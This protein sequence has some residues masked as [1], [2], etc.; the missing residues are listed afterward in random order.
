M[1]GITAF[2]R[3][4]TRFETLRQ[5]GRGYQKA[6]Q[7]VGPAQGAPFNGGIAE[8]SHFKIAGYEF[9]LD[10]FLYVLEGS[11]RIED[12]ENDVWLTPGQGVFIPKG[13]VVTIEV[14]DRMVWVYVSSPAFA[15]V[16]ETKD[17]L[18]E[19]S[20]LTEA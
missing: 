5:V 18:K 12:A 9:V 11:V 8:L 7:W 13:T 20:S 10:D 3:Q 17:A 1:P 15:S 2:K 4:G 19:P 6:G 16:G 14:P